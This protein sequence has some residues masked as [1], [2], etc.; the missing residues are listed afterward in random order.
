M[1]HCFNDGTT[2]QLELYFKQRWATM[3][4]GGGD[5]NGSRVHVAPVLFVAAAARHSQLR[6]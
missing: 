1:L 6:L 5:S 2:D 3:S 4:T